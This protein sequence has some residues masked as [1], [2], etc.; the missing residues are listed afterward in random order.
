M[1]ETETY[2]TEESFLWEASR[3]FLRGEMSF[4]ERQTISERYG[5][6]AYFFSC[7]GAKERSTLVTLSPETEGA[8][9]DKRKE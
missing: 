1:K 2:A 7:N 4:E 6:S 8:E 3:R 9:S 5:P